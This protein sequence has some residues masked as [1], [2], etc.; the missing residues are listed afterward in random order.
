[1]TTL[2]ANEEME[3][4]SDNLS[5][6]NGDHL[7]NIA[8]GLAL[9]EAANQG[10]FDKNEAIQLIAGSINERLGRSV[11]AEG[12]KKQVESFFQKN[13]SEYLIGIMDQVKFG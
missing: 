10:T 11:D 4:L 12:L 8:S 1:M 9:L 2:C 7:R 5:E 3:P 6:T 13:A